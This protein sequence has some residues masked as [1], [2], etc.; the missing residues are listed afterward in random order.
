MQL[1]PKLKEAYGGRR[2]AGNSDRSPGEASN[3]NG[4]GR[5]A[6]LWPPPR[7]ARS[8]QAPLPAREA[9]QSVVRLRRVFARRLD[10]PAP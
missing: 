8:I 10:E 5:A 1:R 3:S 2:A 6:I 7:R 9:F 4:G